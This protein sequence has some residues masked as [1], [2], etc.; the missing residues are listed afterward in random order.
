VY[1]GCIVVDMLVNI[2]YPV[3]VVVVGGV[4]VFVVELVW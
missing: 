2:Y 4:I 1:D 3:G